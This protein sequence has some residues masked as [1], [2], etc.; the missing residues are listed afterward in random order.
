MARNKEVNIYKESTEQK[1]I[2]L[3]ENYR[4]CQ[5]FAAIDRALVVDPAGKQTWKLLVK[6]F[7]KV[8]HGD[9]ILDYEIVETASFQC[10]NSETSLLGQVLLFDII[11][12]SAVNHFPLLLHDNSILKEKEGTELISEYDTLVLLNNIKMQMFDSIMNSV[13]I[14]GTQDL[15]KKFT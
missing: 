1:E 15:S 12:M 13:Q 14:V 3:Y 5:T 2:S 6:S 7:K 9:T 4:K 8:Q 11:A 10:P